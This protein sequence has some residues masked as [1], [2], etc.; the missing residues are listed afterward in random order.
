MSSSRC[1]SGS[2]GGS[3]AAFILIKVVSLP[4]A[5]IILRQ[6]WLVFE[7]FFYLLSE[8]RV[9]RSALGTRDEVGTYYSGVVVGT[10][11]KLFDRTT[12]KALAFYQ[13][14]DHAM[15]FFNGYE[16]G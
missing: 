9:R 12:S 6:Q 3:E 7:R 16:H 13:M 5:G 8:V 14:S 4:P 1:S 10:K 2:R 15:L 11:G